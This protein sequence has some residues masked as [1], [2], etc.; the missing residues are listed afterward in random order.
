MAVPLDDFDVILG[1]DFFVVAKVALMPYFGGLLILDENQ[2]CFVSG[3]TRPD[4]KNGTKKKDEMLLAVQV[5]NGLRKD[6]ETFLAA[7]IEMKPDLTMEVPDAV[8]DV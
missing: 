7:L 8:A 2:P 6:E 5:L 1:N 3:S 4:K